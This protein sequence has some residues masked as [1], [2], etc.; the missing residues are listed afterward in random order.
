M[1]TPFPASVA[2]PH[3]QTE[4]WDTIQD[5]DW[6]PAAIDHILFGH[7]IILT[8]ALGGSVPGY[9]LFQPHSFGSMSL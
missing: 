8:G 4:G 9:L 3:I 5:A 2:S 7:F 6:P 1:G